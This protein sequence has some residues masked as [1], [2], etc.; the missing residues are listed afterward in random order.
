MLWRDRLTNQTYALSEQFLSK[1]RQSLAEQIVDTC[2]GI[3]DFKSLADRVACFWRDTYYSLLFPLRVELLKSDGQLSGKELDDLTG[4]PLQFRSRALQAGCRPPIF[5]AEDGSE[6]LMADRVLARTA[7]LTVTLQ[8]TACSQDVLHRL[9]FAS[10]TEPIFEEVAGSIA[11]APSVSDYVRWLRSNCKENP[12]SALEQSIVEVVSSLL[13]SSQHDGLPKIQLVL[14]SVKRVKQYVFDTGGLNEIRGASVMLDITIDE[15]AEKV[16]R[17]IGP[18]VVLRHA[19]ATIQFL[20]PQHANGHPN[21]TAIIQETFHTQ[22]PEAMAVAVAVQCAPIEMRDNAATVF[23]QANRNLEEQR[24]QWKSPIVETLPFETRCSICRRRAAEGWYRAPNQR[25]DYICSI[26][27]RKREEGRR[28]RSRK[29]LDALKGIDICFPDDLGIDALSLEEAI[30]DWFSSQPGDFE[31]TDESS[32]TEPAMIPAD[33][34]RRLLA[35]IYADGNNFG[36]VVQRL[37]SLAQT[38]QWTQRVRWTAQHLAA[39]SLA[40]A[41]STVARSYRDSVGA[42]AEEED[43]ARGRRRLRLQR[44]PFQILALGGDD[45]IIF[46]WGP[47][48]LYFAREFLR[49]TDYEFQ[50]N[51]EKNAAPTNASA[52]DERITFSVGMLL[53]DDKT[54]AR[55]AVDFTEEHLLKWAKRAQRGRGAGQASPGAT[56]SNGGNLVYFLATT[57]EQIPSDLADAVQTRY[58]IKGNQFDLCLSLRPFNQE[59]WAWLLDIAASLESRKGALYR[60]V[61]A[62]ITSSPAAAL[63]HAV[64]QLAREGRG[65]RGDSGGRGSLIRDTFKN[66][67]RPPSLQAWEYPAKALPGRDPLGDERLSNTSNTTSGS[68]RTVLLSPLADIVEI[69]KVLE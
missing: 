3:S 20:A 49:W 51:D 26:C 30:P 9:R 42:D 14:G 68:Q 37:E 44:L 18:E 67:H 19:G 41:T 50:M 17:D 1:V 45:L 12:P 8:G 58:L 29:I 53:A 4:E 24:A 25:L 47:V 5:P 64:Y 65:G 39:L 60:L 48:A 7:L 21:W 31:S 69:M 43:G 66:G 35:V 56:T 15:L 40:V 28:F 33:V 34:R 2:R 10:L 11:G 27:A 57:A 61:A 63:L 54:P 32:L 16:S 55:R 6:D 59:E 23:R 62:M 38:I 52:R 46:A 36:R 22:C 13:G